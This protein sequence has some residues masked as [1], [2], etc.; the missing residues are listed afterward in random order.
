MNQGMQM[1]EWATELFPIARSLKFPR[2]SGR[3]RGSQVT[4]LPSSFSCAA[5]ALDSREKNVFGLGCTSLQYNFLGTM[6]TV[7]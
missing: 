1:H 5:S 3:V 6:A 4:L 2:F 7:R